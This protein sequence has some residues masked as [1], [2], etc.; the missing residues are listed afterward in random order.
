[1][2]I[3]FKTGEGTFIF[4][5]A[6]VILHDGKLL[7][8]YKEKTDHYYLPGGRLQLHEEL[9]DG[10]L[11]EVREELQ[12]EGEVVRPLWLNQCFF[13][14]EKDPNGVH[15]MTLFYLVNISKSDLLLRG[16]RFTLT[17]GNK[18]H[19]FRWVELEDL[20]SLR[21]NPHFIKNEIKTLPQEL[22]ILCERA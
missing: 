12:V 21:V 18:T 4:R 3:T 11:R 13:K 6:A 22:T 10:I 8:L 2:N 9:V 1:M 14:N 5:V 20:Q 16:E 15:E 17:E 7:M 19:D